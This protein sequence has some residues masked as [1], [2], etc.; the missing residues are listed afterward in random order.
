VPHHGH[1]VALAPATIPATSSATFTPGFDPAEPGKL[2]CFSVDLV[3]AR[4]ASA[5][6]GAR[7][8]ADTKFASTRAASCPTASSER[9][10]AASETAE[11]IDKMRG[12]AEAG[13]WIEAQPTRAV[14][15]RLPI[16]KPRW[17]SL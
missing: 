6:T 9:T 14:N 16:R 7:Q 2:K 8:A 10:G 5:S 17:S 12:I 4:T 1:V 11:H 15:D 13:R 3:P